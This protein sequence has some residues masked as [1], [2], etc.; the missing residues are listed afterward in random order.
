MSRYVLPDLKYFNPWRAAFAGLFALI[1]WAVLAESAWQLYY[2]WSSGEGLDVDVHGYLLAAGAFLIAAIT[3]TVGLRRVFLWLGMRRQAR[4]QVVVPE[5]TSTLSPVEAGVILDAYSDAREQRATKRT[6]SATTVQSV[7]DQAYIRLRDQGDIQEL[8][9][10]GTVA[11]VFVRILAPFG[12]FIG[13]LM[14]IGIFEPQ[15]HVIGYPR[16]DVA[17]WQLFFIVLL[18]IL[19]I[20]IPVQAYF[21]RIFTKSGMEKYRQAA[22]LYMY[23]S[24]VMRDRFDNGELSAKETAYYLPYAQAFGIEKSQ[25]T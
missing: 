2:A 23:I 1:I 14:F 16:Y 9:K 18:L 21:S 10:L 7:R 13:L 24:T 25:T 5:Y 15:T 20:C 22:G 19:A 3:A 11:R 12:Y 17:W 8:S 6:R 4:N